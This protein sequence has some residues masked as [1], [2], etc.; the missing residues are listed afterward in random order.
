MSSDLVNIVSNCI[1]VLLRF[2]TS[3]TIKT[4]PDSY[5]P[6]LFDPETGF[7][8]AARPFCEKYVEACGKEAGE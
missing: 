3:A 1:V 5:E 2:M 7:E 6:F 4:D 8:I